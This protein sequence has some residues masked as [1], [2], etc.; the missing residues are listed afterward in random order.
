LSRFFLRG[1]VT[2]APAVLTLVVFGLLI[3]TVGKYVTG[4]INGAI[5]WS[6]ESNSFGWKVLRRI[7]IDPFDLD[8]VDKNSL[9]VGLAA[10]E[11][12][13]PLG[14]TELLLLRE[15]RSSFFKDFD[16]L[17]INGERL[18]EEVAGRVHPVF[19]VALSLLLVLWLGWMMGSFV[20]KRTVARLDKAMHAIPIVRSVYPYSKQLVEFFFAEKKIEFDTVV[21]VPYPSPGLWS[22]AFVTS[23]AL[24]TLREETGRR[25]VGVFV[26]S[27]PM[28][29]TGYTIFV[30]HHRII[31]VSISVDEA[32]RITM[33]GGVLIPDRERVD[34]PMVDD[35]EPSLPALE[36]ALRPDSESEAPPDDEDDASAGDTKQQE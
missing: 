6:L 8:F 16:E 36:E 28:P 9:P 5:Y 3:Q 10:E 19:G 15:E 18:R 7:E 2:L 11:L 14:K 1:L 25:F 21:F 32:L 27:S 26:P 33:T 12:A 34:D 30:E 35:W 23:S 29:M 22:I 24:K 20:G 17:A 4:P 31:P 13:T